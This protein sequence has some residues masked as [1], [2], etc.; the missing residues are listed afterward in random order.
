M[1][2]IRFR[3]KTF[4]TVGILFILILSITLP[5]ILYK[6]YDK[7]DD[8]FLL[9][10][11]QGT[12]GSFFFENDFLLHIPYNH[13]DRT[14]GEQI[15]L[16]SLLMGEKDVKIENFKDSLSS[17]D[18]GILHLSKLRGIKTSSGWYYLF[19]NGLDSYDVPHV[20]GQRSLNFSSWTSSPLFNFNTVSENLSKFV[21]IEKNSKGEVFGCFSDFLGKINSSR[22]YSFLIYSINQNMDLVYNLTYGGETDYYLNSYFTIFNDSF[23]INWNYYNSTL[24]Q[25]VSNL[26]VSNDSK[27]WSNFTLYFPNNDIFP[28][29]FEV[30]ANK[31]SIYA[32]GLNYNATDP[33]PY[34]KTF[35][36]SNTYTNDTLTSELLFTLPNQLYFN[37]KS[38]Y[39]WNNGSVS[40]FFTEYFETSVNSYYGLYS[41]GVLSLNKIAYNSSCNFVEALQLDIRGEK[42]CLLWREI[43]SDNFP[44]EPLKYYLYFGYFTDKTSIDLMFNSNISIIEWGN[45]SLLQKRGMYVASKRRKNIENLL[46]NRVMFV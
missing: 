31:I 20:I 43:H 26:I 38:I 41:D 25:V 28:C 22:Y 4:V 16:V 30:F 36:Y 39:T 8:T 14:N 21:G 13:V 17:W 42:I 19:A 46:E 33:E 27:R 45:G 7:N 11:K 6:F 9:Q 44:I 32:Y 29:G 3:N 1:R 37:E 40:I 12:I 5:I 23:V 2:K 34:S 35:L 24:D 15:G 10:I 18:K